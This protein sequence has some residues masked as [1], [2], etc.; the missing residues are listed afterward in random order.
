MA[1]SPSENF[2]ALYARLNSLYDEG[3]YA[4]GLEA[5]L[6]GRKDFPESANVLCHFGAC[7]AARLGDADQAFKLLE[8]ALAGGYW[9]TVN[10]WEDEDFESIRDLPA[11]ERLRA[12]SMARLEAA[13]A[14]ARPELLTVLPALGVGAMPLLLALHGNASSVRWHRAHWR[15]AAHAGWL[16]GMPQSS[17][18]AGPDSEGAVTFVWNDVPLARREILDHYTALHKAYRLDRKRIVL[19]GFSRGAE[20]A[21]DLAVTGAVPVRGFVAVCPGGPLTLEPERWEPIIAEGEGRGLRG[22]VI[23]GGQDRRLAPGTER[24][25]ELL[26]GVGI[27]CK[28]EIHPDMGHD[29]P[30]D[31][32]ARLGDHLAFAL[33]E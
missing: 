10:G 15:G 3:K 29:Y 9:L 8:E 16:V 19:G 21:I 30:A 5:A 27:P 13:Q 4:E 2:D 12:A 32:D 33:G 11:F 14:D 28:F 17:Q 31:F 24:L 22:T 7:L 23:M 1:G 18:A 25:V 6:Q 20:M 26:R